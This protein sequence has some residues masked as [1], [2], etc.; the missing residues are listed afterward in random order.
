MH[1]RAFLSALTTSDRAGLLGLSMFCFFA[2]LGT[3]PA[4]I[5]LLI[6][7]LALLPYRVFDLWKTLPRIISLLALVFFAYVIVLSLIAQ[8]R[9]PEFAEVHRAGIW[10]WGSL[11]LVVV[12]AYWLAVFRRCWPLFL[13]LAVVGLT[14]DMAIAIVQD[15][16]HYIESLSGYRFNFGKPQLATGFYAAMALIA[17]FCLWSSARQYLRVPVLI[18]AAAIWGIC[19]MVQ[20]SGVVFTQPRVVWMALIAVLVVVVASFLI[21]LAKNP[22]TLKRLSWTPVVVFLLVVV[23]AWVVMPVIEKRLADEREVVMSIVEND[24]AL[25][26][27]NSSLVY[28]IGLLVYGIELVKSKPVL[29]HG[30]GTS[31]PLIKM[32]AEPRMQRWPHLHNGYLEVMVRLGLLGAVLFSAWLVA[33]LFHFMKNTKRHKCFSALRGF[34]LLNL[35]LLLVYSIG[36]YRLDHVDMRFYWYIV[37]GY[38]LSFAFPSVIALRLSA[39]RRLT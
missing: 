4:Y 21:R 16:S 5:G 29:G 14:I 32:H 19:F 20:L 28:R 9:V 39:V 12:V 25:Y 11:L 13:A 2:W 18:A 30:P 23:S 17:L 6:M 27:H 1:I 7:L 38:M 31:R 34:I 26:D 22:F 24:G 8:W 10:E 3:S 33:M 15:W 35:V 37:I 36:N